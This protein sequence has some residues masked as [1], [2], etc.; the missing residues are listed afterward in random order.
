MRVKE[1]EREESQRS[2]RK[3]QHVSVRPSQLEFAAL[4]Q[5][6]PKNYKIFYHAPCLPLHP[7]PSPFCCP[8]ISQAC[9]WLFAVGS[10]VAIIRLDFV[11]DYKFNLNF[12]HEL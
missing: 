9:F 6:L 4:L 7:P 2:A 11:S 8:P 1:R 10:A 3:R 12:N 5:S